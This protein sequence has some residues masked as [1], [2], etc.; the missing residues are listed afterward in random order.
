M[1]CIYNFNH[2]KFLMVTDDPVDNIISSIPWH[3]QC[4]IGIRLI[5]LIDVV[6]YI[7]KFSRYDIGWVHKMSATLKSGSHSTPLEDNMYFLLS[8]YLFKDKH[9]LA[10]GYGHDFKL[11]V[12]HP[13]EDIYLYHRHDIQDINKSKFDGNKNR[14]T[15]VNL[16]TYEGIILLE[17]RNFYAQFLLSYVVELEKD[18]PD[19]LPLTVLD[20][21]TS[22]LLTH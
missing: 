8:M 20:S 16:F 2:D 19:G 21:G 3:P 10:K 7:S 4:T 12:I 13:F 17:I 1:F 18:F 22:E 14:F 11:A 5:D 9:N 15:A 6:E